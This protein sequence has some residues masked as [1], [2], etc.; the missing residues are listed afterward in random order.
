VGRYDGPIGDLVRKYKYQSR[1]QLDRPLGRLLVSSIAGHLPVD[2]IDVIVPVPTTRS[3]LMKYRFSPVGQLAEA[4]S[5]DLGIPVI[6]A[7]R[8]NGKQRRQTELPE[9]QRQAN[10]RGVFHLDP[11]T[12]LTDATVCMLDDVCTSGATFHEV[13]RTLKAAGARRVFAACIAKAV[14][15]AWQATREAFASGDDDTPMALRPQLV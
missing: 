7:L 5:Q 10:V 3:S 6:N 13:A 15:S 12:D 11:G 8:V 9:S 2:A 1:Q 14:P 4:V